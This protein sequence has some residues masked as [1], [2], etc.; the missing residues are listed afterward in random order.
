MVHG[1]TAYDEDSSG[2]RH[3]QV[4]STIFGQSA[5][6]RAYS[7]FSVINFIEILICVWHIEI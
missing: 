1:R 2:K 7:K 4:Q 6:L 3:F 5:L